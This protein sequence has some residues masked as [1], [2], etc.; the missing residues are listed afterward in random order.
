MGSK[1]YRRVEVETASQGRLI[2]MLFNGAISRAVEA[3]RQIEANSGT[4]AHEHLI[5]AQDIISELRNALNMDA[6]EV[7][8]S[9]DR[10]Y[11]YFHHLLVT[12]NIKKATGPIEECVDLMTSMRDTWQELFSGIE[13]EETVEI[14]PAINKHG[15]SVMN[16]E[17]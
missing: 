13:R 14:P 3:Q 1:A 5:Q 7:A 16:L 15:A 4:G 2:V 11:E 17:G 12:A 10:S 9:L 8:L 6:G